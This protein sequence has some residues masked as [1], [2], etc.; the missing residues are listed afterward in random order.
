MRVLLPLVPEGD[1]YSSTSCEVIGIVGAC[2]DEFI[3]VSADPAIVVD[4]FGFGR[5]CV[6]GIARAVLVA[7]DD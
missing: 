2:K 4:A 7:S 5:L 6:Y 3:G 1:P